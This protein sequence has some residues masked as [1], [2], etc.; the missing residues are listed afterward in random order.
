MSATPAKRAVA[1]ERV[2]IPG[3]AGALEALVEEARA[4]APVVAVVCHPHPLHGGTMTN[5]VVH[6][7]GRALNRLG[8]MTIRF[9]FR[10]VGE[11]AGTYAHGIGEREDAVAVVEWARS[12]RPDARLVLAGFSFGAA[13]AVSVAARLDAAA[14]VSVAL[15][16]ERLPADLVLPTCPWLVVHGSEDEIVALDDVRRWLERQAAD[17]RFAVIEGA[18]HFF[19][20]KLTVL[21]DAVAAFARDDVGLGSLA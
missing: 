7:V 1:A 4:P 14:L 11:S 17:A 20:G 2:A 6:T 16:V 12:V 8:A 9:N 3:P 10:G 5:K 21:A 19:H 13:V 15:P 18:T